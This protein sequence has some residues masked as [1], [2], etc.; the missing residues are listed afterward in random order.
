MHIFVPTN[1]LDV[2]NSVPT[3]ATGLPLQSS[4]SLPRESAVVLP[5]I[6][7]LDPPPA[8]DIPASPRPHLDSLGFDPRDWSPG[9]PRSAQRPVG[10]S[11]TGRP[12]TVAPTAPLA[13][14]GT[15]V[16]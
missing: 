3:L 11:A 9:S 2:E 5:M 10:S 8:D 6:G 13:M 7:A 4:A 1:S 15:T 16:S 14:A 12:T